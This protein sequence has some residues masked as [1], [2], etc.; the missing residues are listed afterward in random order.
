MSDRGNARMWDGR[1]PNDLNDMPSLQPGTGANRDRGVAPF[2]S[3]SLVRISPGHTNC[4]GR[5]ET[6][7]SATWSFLAS[8]RHYH[9]ATSIS[10]SY[11]YIQINTIR[12]ILHRTAET[13]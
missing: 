5:P 3:F 8:S 10:E 11:P 12:E 1:N 6:L 4:A 9:G 13:A 7:F 2:S